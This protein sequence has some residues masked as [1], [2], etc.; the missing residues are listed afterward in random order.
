MYSVI[1]DTDLSRGMD[2]R[3][4]N[5]FLY[6]YVHTHRKPSWLVRSFKLPDKKR[7]TGEPTK[8]RQTTGEKSERAK[9][10]GEEKRGM[11]TMYR[12]GWKVKRVG[13]R[14]RK[15]N[16]DYKTGGGTTWRVQS[17]E[18]SRIIEGNPTRFTTL[19]WG[20]EKSKLVDCSLFMR[21]LLYFNFQNIFIY[22]NES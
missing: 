12:R 10:R 22:R 20:E 3:A 2:V 14:G 4:R 7:K 15:G 6:V 17:Y 18:L 11:T 9:C 8:H 16:R 13:K 19:V 21:I 5:C 1:Y